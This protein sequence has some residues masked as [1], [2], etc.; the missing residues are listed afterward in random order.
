MKNASQN[1]LKP[2][3]TGAVD[4]G[5]RKVHQ[6]L[7]VLQKVCSDIAIEPDLE[8]V[9]KHVTAWVA[10]ALQAQI[11]TLFLRDEA[12]PDWLVLRAAYGYPAHLL[13]T[14]TH[15]VGEGI[16]GYIVANKQK[17]IRNSAVSVRRHSN[18]KGKLDAIRGGVCNTL[19]GY[20]ICFRKEPAI[21]TLKVENKLPDRIGRP[22]RFSH[23][24][25]LVLE[26]I[27]G[28]FAVKLKADEAMR[29]TWRA[30][31]IARFFHTFRSPLFTVRGMCEQIR[32]FV[33]DG[34]PIPDLAKKVSI[35][36]TDAL[37]FEQLVNN[38]A[39]WTRS[40]AKLDIEEIDLVQITGEIIDRLREYAVYKKASLCPRLP[41]EQ[42]HK[43][44]TDRSLFE[45]ILVNLV[46]N[47]IEYGG[48]EITVHLEIKPEEFF[49]EVRDNGPGMT[50]DEKNNATQAYYRGVNST[51]KDGLGLGLSVCK[52]AVDLLDGKLEFLNNIPKGLR[53][54]VTIPENHR[55][56]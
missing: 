29:E 26:T 38:S 33:D 14:R 12:D 8:E 54:R 49:L 56:L 39:F 17:V 13:N 47:S 42:N 1:S 15:R 41:E 7:G 44:P 34:E 25:E 50:E 3:A 35:A 6:R 52:K 31:N 30:E 9:M 43:F 10:S 55:N 2:K 53:V 36:Y 27:C 45:L 24:D 37:R 48:G 51:R 4:S 32:A 20:P 11:C 21:G 46:E 28:I 19:L 22:R 18:W 16:T 5:I 23:D 40:K